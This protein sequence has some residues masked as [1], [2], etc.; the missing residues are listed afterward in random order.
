[1][2]GAAP[3]LGLGLWIVKHIVETMGG[4][5]SVKSTPREG[6]TFTVTLPR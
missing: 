3:G 2:E 5:V 6:A 1:V 4:A